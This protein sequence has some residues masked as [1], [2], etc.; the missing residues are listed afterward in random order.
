MSYILKL[1]EVITEELPQKRGSRNQGELEIAEASERFK[2]WGK[3]GREGDG[4]Q[5]LK[6][7]GRFLTE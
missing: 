1:R 7:K 5:F 2:P 6:Y 4:K 3:D